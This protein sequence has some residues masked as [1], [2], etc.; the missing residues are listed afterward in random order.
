MICSAVLG[1]RSVSQA[2]RLVLPAAWWCGSRG[3]VEFL[4]KSLNLGTPL[5]DGSSD[6]PYS[7]KEDMWDGTSVFWLWWKWF[8]SMVWKE[9]SWL[10][11]CCLCNG[12]WFYPQGEDCSSFVYLVFLYYP[13]SF[14]TNL[15][16]WKLVC[17][18]ILL[19]CDSIILLMKTMI[20]GM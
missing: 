4:A 2:G 17:F 16:K 9:N 13:F 12:Y 7:V 15:L 3:N 11:I 8:S 6:L 14:L 5:K 10:D 1:P 18:F 19:W 20:S